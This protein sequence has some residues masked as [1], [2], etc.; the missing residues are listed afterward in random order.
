MGISLI[1]KIFSEQ[2]IF[3][4]FDGFSRIKGSFARGV[5]DFLGINEMPLC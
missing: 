2:R 5:R 3:M 4:I 1:L